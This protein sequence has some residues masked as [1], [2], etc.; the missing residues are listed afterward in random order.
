MKYRL[1]ATIALLIAL[2]S[3][4]F[5]ATE[6]DTTSPMVAPPGADTNALKNLNIN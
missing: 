1:V 5:L 3:A 6:S 4:A 2:A